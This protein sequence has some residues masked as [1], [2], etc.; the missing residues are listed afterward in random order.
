MKLECQ[1]GETSKW[2]LL[3]PPVAHF[4]CHCL[5]ICFVMGLPSVITTDQGREFNNQLN[6]NLTKQFGIN[7]RLTTPYHPQADGLDE[8]FNQTLVNAVAKLTQDHRDTWDEKIGEVVF[9]YNTAV[10]ESTKHTPFEVMFGRMAKLPIDFNM[11]EDISP[12]ER[13]LDFEACHDPPEPK[14]IARKAVTE[15][16]VKA[17]IKAAQVQE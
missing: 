2:A 3:L 5:Q 11:P 9:A 6:N 14:R 15:E 17:N 4:V 7:H 1:N 10:H 16:T 8:R 12:E 13:V